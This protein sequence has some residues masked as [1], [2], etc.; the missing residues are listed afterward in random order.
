M[1]SKQMFKISTSFL[2]YFPDL[3]YCNKIFKGK[4]LMIAIV[5]VVVILVG[6]R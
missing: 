5:A 4:G 3:N 1:L 6:N 2:Y